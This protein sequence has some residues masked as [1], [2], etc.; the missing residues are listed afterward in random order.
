M[1]A[2]WPAHRGRRHRRGRAPDA[3]RPGLPRRRRPPGLLI[4][5]DGPPRPVRLRL[6]T[7]NAA[8]GRDLRDG[9]LSSDRMAAAV[10]GLGADVVAVQE[11]DHLLPRSG[12]TD[13]AALVAAACAAG[14]PAWQHRFA[15]AVHGTPGSRDTFRTAERTLATEPSYGIALATRFPVLQW[16]E[17][18]MAPAR[19]QLPVVLP[20]GAPQR[21][22]WVPD[23]QRVALAAV[24]QTPAGALTVIST[25][26]SFSPARAVV[27][28]RQLKAWSQSLPRPLV[29]M[30]D[31]NLP[32]PLAPRTSG[33][34]SLV[35]AKTFPSPAPRVQLDHVLADAL[36]WQVTDARSERVG[37]SDHRALVVDLALP[38]VG[39]AVT[40]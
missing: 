8:S 21:V 25:H 23:E 22:L 5:A 14:G 16:H 28:L 1:A 30:G 34:T 17:L 31:L 10:A 37:G 20:A 7:V 2:A 40:G 36:H 33:W 26:L 24:V 3:G 4:P 9:K 29:L 32:G 39:E 11:V 19:A 27:Q 15:A 18:R 12:G 38:L 35:R 6:A 13:Q